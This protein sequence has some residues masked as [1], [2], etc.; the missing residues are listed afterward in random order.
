[1]RRFL[2]PL[3]LV[4]VL[5]L[6]VVGLVRAFPQ[7]VA[8]VPPAQ[9]ATATPTPMP[10]PVPLGDRE[11]PQEPEAVATPGGELVRDLSVSLVQVADGFDD[12]INVVSANDGSGR[13]FVV[14][15]PGRVQ[16]IDAEG[17]PLDEPFLDLTTDLPALNGVLDAFLEQGLYDIAFHPDYAE[18]GLF[19]VHFASLM[20]NG[21]SLIVEYQVS[22]DNPD[23]ADPET[24]RG[25]LHIPQPWAN[26]NGGELEFGPDGYLYIG[27]GDGGWEGDPLKTG[28][29]LGDLLGSLLRI[30][31]DNPT[32][33]VGYAIPENNPFVQ[34][35]DVIQLFGVTEEEFAEILPHAV[36]EQYHYG[37]RN[38]WKFH[39]DP[40][41]GDLFMPDVGQNE[42]EEIN[43]WPADGEA[44]QNFG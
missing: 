1:M 19:Y 34:D 38:P 23:Q 29:Y 2:L 17:E 20:R 42:W 35:L 6:G 16:I 7:Q 14:E 32:P 30:D 27:S 18:N 41:T 11:V 5:T 15:R 26:H 8:A 21:D 13:L 28:Q 12:P 43:F 22:D 9:E 4:L 24:A 37:L 39:F 33:G 40:V 3:L 25:I 44:G 31:V 10:T 36:P